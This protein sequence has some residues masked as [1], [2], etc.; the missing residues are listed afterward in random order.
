[1]LLLGVAFKQSIIHKDY[2]FYL[3]DLFYTRGYCSNLQPRKYTRKL[4]NRDTKLIKE[5]YGY[6]F[7]TFTFTSLDFI[8]ALE[9]KSYKKR[10]ISI[11]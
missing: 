2:L 8:Y 7:S 6:E 11:F 1:V 3:Y 9:K 4:I 5:Y 10:I